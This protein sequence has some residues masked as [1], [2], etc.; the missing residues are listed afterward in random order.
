MKTGRVLATFIMAAI[1]FFSATALPVAVS[2]IEHTFVVSQVNMTHLCK[3]TP[4]TVVNGQLPGPMINVTE[5]DLVVVHVINKSPSNI[6]IHWHGIRQWLNCWADG[7]PMITQYPILPNHNFTYRLNVTGQEGTLWWHAHVPGLRA[8]LHGAF[9]IRPRHGS[10]SYPFPKPD[11]EVPII[12]GDWWTMDLTLLEKHFKK[13][14]VDDLPV[15]ATIN[16]KI[17]DLHNCSG[18][19]EDGYVLDVEPGKTY[20]LRIINAV[21]FSEYYLKI[22][23][24][25]FTVVAAD[26]NY[27]KPYTTDVIAVAPGETVDAL[28]VANASPGRYY[29]VALPNQA[30]LPDPQIPVFATRGMVQYKHDHDHG[31]EEE[32]GAPSSNVP[33]LPEM[34]DQHDT[35]TSFYFRSNLTSLPE[36]RRSQLPAQAD[37]SL[38]I[39]LGLGSFCPRGRS[40]SGIYWRN[41]SVA[42]ATMNNVSFH[43]PTDMAVPLLDVQYCHCNS[44]SSGVELYTLPDKPPRAFNY[45][46]PVLAQWDTRKSLLLER[47]RR[48]TVVR[49]FRYGAVVD[50]VFQ[51]TSLLQS[52]ANPMHLHGHDMFMLAQGHGNY[53]AAK[54]VARY[55]LVDPPMRNTVMV[56]RVGWVAIRF[57]ADNPGVWFMHCHY[58]FHLMM[59]MAA[60]FI[61]EDG[62]TLDS[63]LPPPPVNHPKC[64]HLNCLME[65]E[66]FLRD[67]EATSS[68]A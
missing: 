25:K 22:A 50:M 7:V 6:T 14:I 4:V 60:V 13:E 19:V 34:P 47:T 40:C 1:V 46:D 5:G 59:G 53:D 64:Y 32:E 12:I 45:T 43:L 63:V 44:T 57:V 23:G 54:D 27:V 68:P 66:L 67:S 61:V 9:I 41:H 2:V 17:G 15:A 55:N 16:G 38:F 10:S 20:L 62:R 21:L 52:D 30:P 42:A 58:E 31:E 8:T 29:M 56:P 65:N 3:E 26:A 24:H 18:V 28:V 51:S 33:L 11:K 37:E 49:R 39:T 36:R 48:A 35:M